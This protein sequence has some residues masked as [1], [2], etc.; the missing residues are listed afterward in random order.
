MKE[1]GFILSDKKYT[2]SGEKELASLLKLFSS[3]KN[4]SSVIHWNILM[5][6]DSDLEK[7]VTSYQGLLNCLK[8]LNEK[9]SF[10]L[11]VKL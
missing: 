10:L 4:V 8:Y 3:N 5:E 11:L 2:V 6:L 9:N 7:I 1:Y